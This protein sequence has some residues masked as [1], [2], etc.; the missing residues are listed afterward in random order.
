MSA[1]AADDTDDRHSD[2]SVMPDVLAKGR[3]ACYKVIPRSLNPIPAFFSL[4]LSSCC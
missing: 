4:L 2:G 1:T 3:E